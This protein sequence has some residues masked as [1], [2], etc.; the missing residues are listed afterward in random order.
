[1]QPRSVS[2]RKFLPDS[3]LRAMAVAGAPRSFSAMCQELHTAR[4][5]GATPIW[6]LKFPWE[7]HA[8]GFLTPA[9]FRDVSKVSSGYLPTL[10]GCFQAN[11]DYSLILGL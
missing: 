11:P 7:G 3:V 1:M 5:S 4:W 8:H 6:C 9:C 2:A 10:L